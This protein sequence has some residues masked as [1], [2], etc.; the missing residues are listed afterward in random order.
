MNFFVR[1]DW[2]VDCDPTTL[3]AD[4]ETAVCLTIGLNIGKRE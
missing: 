1:F 4:R 3:P 2:Q